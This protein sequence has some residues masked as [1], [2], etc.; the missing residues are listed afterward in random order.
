MTSCRNETIDVL[1]GI[2][3]LT[4]ILG[5][6]LLGSLD[7]NVFRYII[8]SFHMPLFIFISGYLINMRK[9]ITLSGKGVLKKYWSRMLREWMIALLVYTSLLCVT[10]SV[11]LKQLILYI[12]MPYYHLW[13][14]PVL[15]LMILSAWIIERKIIDKTQRLLFFLVLSFFLIGIYNVGYS[16]FA[17]YRLHYFF[18]FY[19]GVVCKNI[20]Y[21]HCC[22]VSYLGGAFLLFLCIV[23]IF[24]LFGLDYS[25]YRIY[26][27]LPLN[28]ALCVWV[29]VPL[30]GNN[31][32]SSDTL[33]YLGKESLHIYLW[34]VLII[35]VLKRLPISHLAYYGLVLGILFVFLIIIKIKISYENNK[36]VSDCR[37]GRKFL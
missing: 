10:Q 6:A 11:S 32:L 14:V 37:I 35:F 12:L 17:E 27:L 7:D 31:S 28:I 15:F 34:H 8:Y 36:T 2:L 5:H 30:I 16:V 20:N 18:F 23:L 26:F 19:L 33:Q 25:D 24:K 22:R 13:Y 4:V 21:P 29:I 1:K 3:I 9:I